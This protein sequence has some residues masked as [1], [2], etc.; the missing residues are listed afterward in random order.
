MSASNFTYLEN[1]FPLLFNLAQ[2]AEFNL[3]S[4]PT[5]CIFKL[6]A[7]GEKLTEIL[8]EKHGLEFQY[9][10]TFHNR[11]KTLQ[12]EEILPQQVKDLLFMVKNR[13]NDA[14]HENKGSIDDAKLLLEEVFKIS[15]WFFETYSIASDDLKDIK[16]V[17][18]ENIDTRHSLSILE[19]EFKQLEEKFYKLL[20]EKKEVPL[21]DEVA[22]KIKQRSI[23]AASKI[24]M[25]EAETRASIDQQLRDAGWQCDTDTI[26]FK[27]CKT[28]PEKGKY[29]AIAEWKC[30]TLWADYALFNGLQLIGIVE[31]KK[32]IKNVMSDLGQAKIYSKNVKKDFEISFPDHSNYENYQ[33]PFMFST[34]GRPYLEQ[35]K[36][37][38]GIWFWD[39]R[40]QTNV[41]RPLRNWFSPTDL[42]E[43]LLYDETNGEEKLSSTPYDIL[44]DPDGLNLREYQIDAIKAVENKILTDL[45]DR[46]ALLAM[47]TG[48]GKTRTMIGMCYRL[49][50]SGRFRR[51]V[52]LL[53]PRMLGEQPGDAFKE[54]KNV[55]LQ[56]FYKID[57]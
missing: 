9:K 21:A 38:S 7:F 19:N 6:R 18:P 28:L 39:G 17:C 3:Y 55:G 34:N 32:H 2:S 53:D 35:I 54:I 33:V 45:I 13:G 49:I 40:K 16:F 30:E 8:F 11:L 52:F 44:A 24:E 10:N 5:V 43:K 56:S 46:R 1:E 12:F 42:I 51:S 41:P 57:Y 15:K 36:T 14:V 26:N 4:D 22:K 37:A 29:K 20:Q 50:Q 23:K 27:K 47:A 31:A 25:S 48:T